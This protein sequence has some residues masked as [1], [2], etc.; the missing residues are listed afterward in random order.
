MSNDRSQPGEVADFAAQWRRSQR[1]DEDTA[2]SIGL[3]LEEEKPRDAI[4]VAVISVTVKHRFMPGQPVGVIDGVASV[5]NPVGI[6]DPYLSSP[7][8][9]GHWYW[10]FLF[11]GTIS[12][13]NHS[14]THPGL[15]EEVLMEEE[16]EDTP[17]AGES[18]QE[19]V[20]CFDEAQR[21]RDS[22]GWIRAYA[23]RVPISYEVLMAS[24]RV[25]QDD[26]FHLL[27]RGEEFEGECVPDEF[28]DHYA[29][30]TGE[31]PKVRDN[32]F[33]CSC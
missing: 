30:V 27:V 29:I 3:V 24:A 14:W 15:P 2:K 22:E 20:K 10:V 8:D 18:S 12:S 4:H 13:L 25:K 6:I 1:Q 31:E 11:P 9:P 19:V 17:K 28:W 23:R 21:K 16:V 32:F 33:A 26:P 5:D 7:A